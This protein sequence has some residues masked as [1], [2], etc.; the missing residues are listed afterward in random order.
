MLATAARNYPLSRLL[1]PPS[2]DIIIPA[3][4]LADTS[5]FC[6]PT[7]LAIFT[8]NEQVQS[9]RGAFLL[10]FFEGKPLVGI[11]FRRVSF[12]QSSGNFFDHFVEWTSTVFCVPFFLFGQDFHGR[13]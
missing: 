3:F 6:V 5:P 1:S 8:R 10:A 7:F 12:E 11:L 13:L 2:C 4:Y 9:Q